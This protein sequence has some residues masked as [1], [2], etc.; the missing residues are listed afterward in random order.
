MTVE[1]TSKCPEAC[2]DG[3]DRCRSHCVQIQAWTLQ[4]WSEDYGGENFF[5]DSLDEALAGL[6]RIT[7]KSEG[8]G[9]QRWFSVFP[10]DD[11]EL[12]EGDE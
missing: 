4:M 6:G 3:T 12:A 2:Q 8:D 9:T 1:A 7:I 10:S 5:Y 11:D